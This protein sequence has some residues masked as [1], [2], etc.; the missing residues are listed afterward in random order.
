MFHIFESEWKYD[1][2]NIKTFIKNKINKIREF[3]DDTIELDLT[4]HSILEYPEYETKD[5]IKPFKVKFG[6]NEIWNC[7]KA[8]LIKHK[9]TYI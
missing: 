1:K 3:N 5:I 7:G 2:D 4:K 8:I 6:D 9:S